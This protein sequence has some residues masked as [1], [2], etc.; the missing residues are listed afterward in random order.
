V[1]RSLTTFVG[2]GVNQIAFATDD[3]FA[4]AKAM[5]ANGVKFLAIPG[6]YYDD[7]AA[8][9]QLSDDLIDQL[10]RHGILYD[11]DERG[12]EFL[13]VYTELFDGRFFFEIVQRKGGYDQYGA[14]NAAVRM[15]A[16]TRA[17]PVVGAL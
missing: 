14:P 12:G 13:H 2:A 15:A 4:A 8:R 17:A 7:L 3:I 5:A 11:R 6:N 1:A 16:Q 9:F 10:S